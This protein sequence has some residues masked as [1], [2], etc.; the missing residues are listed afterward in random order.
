MYKAAQF[1]SQ[2]YV[3]QNTRVTRSFRPKCFINLGSTSLNNYKYSF[4]NRTVNEWNAL[5]T[6]V[7]EQETH[8][9]HWQFLF[10]FF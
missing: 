1:Q 10:H 9:N 4:F 5:P 7:I 2:I 6:E 3:Q 8:L